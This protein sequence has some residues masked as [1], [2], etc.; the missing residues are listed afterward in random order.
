ML[1]FS[2]QIIYRNPHFLTFKLEEGYLYA[3]LAV[4][5]TLNALILK[6]YLIIKCLVFALQLLIFNKFSLYFINLIINK[7]IN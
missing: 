6:I 7:Y 2:A 1:G 3:A 5:I 4:Q